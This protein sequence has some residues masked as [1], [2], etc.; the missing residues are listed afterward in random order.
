MYKNVNYQ[1]LDNLKP[2]YNIAKIA[3]SNYGIKRSEKV[4][5]LK[6]ESQKNKWLDKDYRNH[7]LSK[8][9]TNWRGGSEHRMA[10]IN[11]EKVLEIKDLLK[12]GFNAVQVSNSLGVSYHIVKDI[13]RNKTWK[14]VK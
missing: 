11:E 3:G 14:N 2:K 1:S 9:S 8:L 13:K 10:K 7:H 6:S 4:K 5:K 12:K